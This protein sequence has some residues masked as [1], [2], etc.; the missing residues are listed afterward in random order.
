M[1]QLN[2]QSKVIHGDL[3]TTKANK[4]KELKE[5]IDELNK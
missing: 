5:Y 2:K 3:E 1:G 4:G